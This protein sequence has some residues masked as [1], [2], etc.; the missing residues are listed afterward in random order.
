MNEIQDRLQGIAVGAVIGDALGMPL[1]FRPPRSEFDLETEMINGPLPAGSFTDDTE[2]ALCLAESLLLTSPLDVQDLAGRFTAWYQNRPPD[3]GVHTA[4]V[5]RMFARGEPITK[6]AQKVQQNEPDS[7]SNG[8]LMRIWPIA[9]ARYKQP[10]LLVSETRLQTELTHVHPDCVNGSLF[11]NF[12]LYQ[13]LQEPQKPPAEVVRRAVQMATDQVA[14]DPDFLLMMNLAPMR[15]R[16]DLKNSGWVCHTLESALWA[17]MT[18]QSFE[19]ALVRVVN[20]GN[21]AD[22]AGCVTGAIAGALYGSSNIPARWK[23][24]IHGEYPLHSGKLWFLK[25]FTNL[26]DQL[27]ALSDSDKNV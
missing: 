1:E 14:L 24:A 13:I 6:A 16:N 4:A 20:L 22:T 11:L 7:A 12:I 3:V 2:M 21:D 10:G 27:A 18:T 23:D 17:V 9:I 25:D 19:E 5:L 8:G 26:A 15:M